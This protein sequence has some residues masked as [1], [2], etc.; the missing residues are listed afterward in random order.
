MSGGMQS[1]ALAKVLKYVLQNL[2][3]ARLIGVSKRA[4]PDW[5]K[6]KGIHLRIGLRE[7]AFDRPYRVVS[8]ELPK[9]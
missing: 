4:S 9:E 5:T 6:S 7:H 8:S 3:R 2:H 1:C